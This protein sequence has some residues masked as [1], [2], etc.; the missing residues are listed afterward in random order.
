[1]RISNE[2]KA[3]WLEDWKGS[4]K[5]ACV[6][7]KEN[8]LNPQTFVRWTKPASEKQVS[9]VEVV[10]PA[11]PAPPYSPEILIEKGDVK[12]HIPL[13]IN[14]SELRAVMEGLGCAL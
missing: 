8:G 5:S 13:A 3:M 6:Y 12:I 11:M 1:M 2:E 4:G 9:F 14:R 7:A 10:P